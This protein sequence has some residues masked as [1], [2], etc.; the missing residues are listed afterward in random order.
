MTLRSFDKL[1]LSLDA[2][3]YHLQKVQTYILS[4]PFRP[5]DY[6]LVVEK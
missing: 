1:L 5:M 6:I 4:T 3:V 2:L